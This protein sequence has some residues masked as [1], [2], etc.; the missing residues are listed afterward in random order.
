MM[1][2]AQLIQ[3]NDLLVSL[4]LIK[5][6]LVELNLLEDVKLGIRWEMLEE[7]LKLICKNLGEDNKS[8]MIQIGYL[9]EKLVRITN[10]IN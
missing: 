6:R 9:S 3:F 2:Y 5:K 10:N 7:D 8:A 1:N 4:T